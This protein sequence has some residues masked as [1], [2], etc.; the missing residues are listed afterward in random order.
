M[1][2]CSISEDF[3]F[4]WV[5]AEGRIDG[6]TSP[7]IHSSLSELVE[8]GERV[9]VVN[10]ERVGY[11]SSAGLRVF[12]IV[13]KQLKKV[14]GE[15][16]LYGLSPQV[17]AV[18]QTAGL[19]GF[20]TTLS[21]REE[22]AARAAAHLAQTPEASTRIGNIDFKKVGRNVE[23]GAY[24]S[25][26][27]QKPLACC[28]YSV[29]DVAEID[30]RALR[31]GLGLACLGDDWGEYK[32]LF[33]EAIVI[34]H[35]LFFYPALKR[36]AVDFMIFSEQ[37]RGVGY[38]FLHGSGFTGQFKYLISFEA[39][40]GL[41]LLSELIEGIFELVGGRHLGVV[42][43]AESKGLWGMNLK[44]VPIVEN[45]PQNGKGIFDPGNFPE[46]MEFPIEPSAF[47]HIVVAAGVAAKDIA[48]AGAL[49]GAD[50]PEE[51]GFHMH[52]AVFA[53][54]PLSRKPESLELELKRVTGELEVF[55]VQHMLGQSGFAGGVAG[56][57]EI[58]G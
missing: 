40:E 32:G 58:E 29:E 9:V 11:V 25:I 36:S 18:F 42:L 8:K 34:E 21:T 1:L 3:G 19:L 44:K 49:M 23:N 24:L 4:K 27:S 10:M 46:W 16:V 57:V 30:P 37:Q 45:R 48:S 52:A 53:K 12:L 20:F 5:N 43:L 28:G 56:I 26:G 17:A 7:Q 50:L 54:G 13:Q 31:F 15:V 41:V 2:Q 14:E 35:S 33:G 39:V 22:I 38:R 6:L 55:R 47:N 51:G